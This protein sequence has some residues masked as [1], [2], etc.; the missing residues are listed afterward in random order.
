M[1]LFNFINHPIESYIKELPILYPGITNAVGCY[2]DYDHKLKILSLKNGKFIFNNDKELIRGFIRFNKKLNNQTW[3]NN[4]SL[5]IND[6]LS[7]NEHKQM[8]LEDE[9]N[10]S[11]LALKTKSNLSSEFDV[12]LL[13]INN[14]NAFGVNYKLKNYT[15]TEK[16]L[17]SNLINS[18]FQNFI[19]NSYENYSALLLMNKSL[20][21][22]NEIVNLKNQNNDLY[23]NKYREVFTQYIDQIIQK[24]SNKTGFKITFNKEY[25][26]D[27]VN[28][29][30]DI[31][32]I[33]NTIIQSTYICINSNIRN[34]QHIELKP[35]YLIWPNEVTSIKNSNH[36]DNSIVEFLDRY[37]MAALK[38]H[39]QGLKIIG[40]IV[41]ECCEP[42]VTAASISFN[43][44]KYENKIYDLFS[45]NKDEWPTLRNKFNPIKKIINT[46]SHAI[47]NIKIA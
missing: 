9:D 40:K 14:S 5:P 43:L 38:A 20:N 19:R 4:E 46:S 32:Q 30:L 27:I 26:D 22:L 6:T 47:S 1:K 8:S 23:H 39:N 31:S 28:S 36:R 25:I 16:A 44:K 29:K 37:E 42:S 21:N 41:G 34:N 7:K 3:L 11:W 13:K 10:N 45:K 18:N 12:F 17:I 24:R 33:E 35:E 15:T 2:F